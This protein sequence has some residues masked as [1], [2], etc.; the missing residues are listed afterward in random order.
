MAEIALIE[1]LDIIHSLLLHRGLLSDG[2]KFI[3]EIHADIHDGQRIGAV[4][5]CPA[6][7]LLSAGRHQ[8]AGSTI[9]SPNSPLGMSLPS[10]K[11]NDESNHSLEDGPPEESSSDPNDDGDAGS[12][13]SEM[14]TMTG[15]GQSR[16][17]IVY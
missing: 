3:T 7:S 14:S 15:Y 16:R 11:D 9:F 8:S 2:N 13:I 5:P 6:P 12:I 10:L 1:Y 4:S 17:Y